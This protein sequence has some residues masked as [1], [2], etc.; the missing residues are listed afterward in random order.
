MKI[1]IVGSGNVGGALAKASV[2][3]GH[4]VTI[5]SR[6]PSHAKAKADATGARAAA[7]PA[8][9]V[10]DAEVVIL[11]VP[12]AAV[13]DVIGAIGDALAGKVVIDVTNRMKR[14]N[15]GESVDGTSGAEHIQQRLPK[16]KVAKAFN[17]A[18]AS[19]QADPRA[20]GVQLD[21]YVAADDADAKAKTLQLVGDVGFRPIDAGP[22]AMA[23]ALEALAILNI[24]LQ[25][26]HGWPWQAG[27]KLVGPTE[28]KS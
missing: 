1:G 26:Q 15:L 19:R 20:D 9:A 24:A 11:A 13:D 6:D 5:G 8:E 25:I 2:R 4:T 14:P 10:S 23:R 16:A 17:Y 3:A 7:S 27:W 18:F 21:G 28:K 22:L 12:N